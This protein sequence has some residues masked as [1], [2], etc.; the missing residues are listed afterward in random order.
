MIVFAHR[1][2]SAYAPQNTVP[3]FKMALAM[4]AQGIELDV[5][6][7]SDGVPVIIHDFMLDKTTDLSGFVHTHSWQELRKADAGLWFG[8]EYRETRIPSL[9]E[10][11]ALIP[12]DV[13]LNVEIKSITSLN[14]PVARIVSQVLNQEKDRNLIVSSFNHPILKDFQ[15]LS[16]EVKIGILTAN[17][18]INFPAYVESSGIRPYSIHP[19]ASYLSYQSIEDYH[20]RGWKVMTYTINSTTQSRMVES[21]GADGIFSDY[22]D[23]NSDIQDSD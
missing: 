16:P 4:K 6:L 21:L 14:Q 13:L 2:A 8:E 1:G 9:E 22:P 11:L 17:D 18:F 12:K 5:Q 10:V 23:L 19:E 20:K 7:S 15:L 3:S